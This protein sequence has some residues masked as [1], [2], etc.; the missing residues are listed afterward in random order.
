MRTSASLLTVLICAL[1]V[2]GCAAPHPPWQLD[3]VDGHLPDLAFRLTS[4]TGET[5]TE[6][7]F[8]GK[9]DLLYFGYTHCPDVC[10]LTLAHLH[11]AMQRL[12]AAADD[13]QILF[14]SVDPARDTPGVLH[15]YVRAFDPHITGLTGPPDDIEA[16]AKRYRAAFDREAPKSDGNYEVSHSS[17]VYIFDRGGKARLLAT[18]GSSVDALTHD[19]G[20]LVRERQ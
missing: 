16:L 4:D 7:N 18:S 17:G 19:I 8:A 14:V 15:E 5:V 20:Q 11:V 6:K 9:I 2:A 1:G 13:V 10:P 12:G 3:D